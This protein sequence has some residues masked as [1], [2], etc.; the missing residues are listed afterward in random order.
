ML[1]NEALARLRRIANLI[2]QDSWTSEFGSSATVPEVPA[3]KN[4]ILHALPRV[5]LAWATSMP[6]GMQL[7]LR[8][9]VCHGHP[10]VSFA[11]AKAPCELGDFL[12]VHDHEQGGVL[13][14]RRAALVQA[15]LF[16]ATGVSVPNSNQFMLYTGWP[17][18]RYTSWPGRMARLFDVLSTRAGI[19]ASAPGVLVRNV[20]VLGPS[21]KAPITTVIHGAR[22]GMIDDATAQSRRRGYWPS[23]WRLLDPTTPDLYHAS[24]G[25]SLPGYLLR[26]VQGTQ[27]R[28]VPAPG[29]P[30]DLAQ[31][32]HWSLVVEELLSLLP[33]AASP[34]SD[35]SLRFHAV[36]G[37][38]GWGTTAPGAGDDG[39]G[40]FAVILAISSGGD[41]DTRLDRER[42]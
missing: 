20:A 16:G 23:V 8:G 35:G 27:G 26:L 19:P 22:Y 33:P 11:G 24:V 42:G 7:R 25:M 9:V 21:A 6:P 34:S 40:A 17:A 14:S 31:A 5:D 37:Q 39:D 30:S 15:K 28:L 12:L 36:G 18:F 4:L 10:R 32:C 29:W 41:V 1:T 38:P 3:I 2:L 13:Q